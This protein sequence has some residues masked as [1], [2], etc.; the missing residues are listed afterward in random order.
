[1]DKLHWK[2]I[3]DKVLKVLHGDINDFSKAIKLI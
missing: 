2:N 3:L 1:M